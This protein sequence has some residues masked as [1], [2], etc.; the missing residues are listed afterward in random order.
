MTTRNGKIARR[1]KAVRRELHCRLSEGDPGASLG[2]WLNERDDV[3]KVLVARFG[4]RPVSEQNLSE[5]RAG[6]YVDGQRHPETRELAQRM[7]DRCAADP[8]VKHG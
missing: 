3:K 2:E 7:N 6:G 4:G 5:W 8:R 1:P